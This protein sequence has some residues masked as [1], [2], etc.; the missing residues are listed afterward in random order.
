MCA[1]KK[2]GK[3]NG[4][5]LQ[6]NVMQLRKV[7]NH[8]FLQEDSYNLNDDLWRCSGKVELM[9][10]LLRKLKKG[11]HRV[12]M[13]SQM[14]AMISIMIDYF[15]FRGYKHMRLDGNTDSQ[16][17]MRLLNDFNAADSE[18]FVF[19]LSTKAGG[20][21]LNL[22]SADTVIIFDSDWNPQADLQAMARAHRI[23]QKKQVLVLRLVTEESVEEQMLT[24]AYQKL[25]NEAMVIQAGMFND[26]H[27]DTLRREKMEALMH[28][29]G[30]ERDDDEID[31]GDEGHAELSELNSR[32]A[33]GAGEYDLFQQWDREHAQE[34]GYNGVNDLNEWLNSRIV[35]KDELPDYLRGEVEIQP[36]PEDPD[37]LMDA[38]GR[39]QRKRT[40]IRYNDERSEAQWLKDSDLII[41]DTAGSQGGKKRMKL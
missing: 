32:I 16:T 13:F 12:L 33:R 29:E 7:C 1:L 38:G 39:G 35:G 6:N 31:A 34:A 11:G 40:E 25:D 10:R 22:Q 23:G 18:Y 3:L 2:T 19:I 24:T 37:V 21:G 30:D 27:D 5:S 20:L 36:D 8:P 14:T 17:R 9:D 15:N 28:A 41:D 4:R 26:R